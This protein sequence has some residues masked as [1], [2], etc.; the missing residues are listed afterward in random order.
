MKAA[1][2]IGTL[3]LALAFATPA[4]RILR[5]RLN[6]RVNDEQYFAAARKR[7]I[8]YRLNRPEENATDAQGS[9]SK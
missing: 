7:A 2:L 1:L 5:A 8:G 4:M 3:G 6:S 9:A